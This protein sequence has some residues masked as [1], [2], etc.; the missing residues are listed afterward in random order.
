MC[1][2]GRSGLSS[3]HIRKGKH[4]VQRCWRLDLDKVGG[5]TRFDDTFIDQLPVEGRFYQNILTLAPG[6]KVDVA[7][8][9]EK[10]RAGSVER[11]VV[12]ASDDAIAR[13]A[14]ALDVL[15]RGRPRT[16]DE[17]V[18]RG[19][20]PSAPDLPADSSLPVTV[21]QAW[22]RLLPAPWGGVPSELCSEVTS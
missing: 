18:A 13:M 16:T 22:G 4:A 7:A 15:R 1:G 5:S 14:A 17:M 9:P 6:D 2:R 8:V 21:V 3:V 19:R 12:V 10:A 20:T 11:T